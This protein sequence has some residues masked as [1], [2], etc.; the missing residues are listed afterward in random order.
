M[1]EKISSTPVYATYLVAPRPLDV[2][3]RFFAVVPDAV[4]GTIISDI[5]DEPTVEAF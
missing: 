2:M 4:D 3:L 5:V 1:V